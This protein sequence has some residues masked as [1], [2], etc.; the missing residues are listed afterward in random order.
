MT[1]ARNAKVSIHHFLRSFAM[2]TRI[3]DPGRHP[4]RGGVLNLIYHSRTL[5]IR[6]FLVVRMLSQSVKP[7]LMA[8][9]LSRRHKENSMKALV[10]SEY[11]KLDIVDVSKPQPGEDDLLIRV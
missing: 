11:K 6:K 5:E 4:P 2:S 1:V 8:F 10:L 7:V 3:R 9:K